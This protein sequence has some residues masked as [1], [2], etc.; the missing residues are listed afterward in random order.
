[1]KEAEGLKAGILILFNPV[2]KFKKV[3]PKAEKLTIEI[4]C[5]TFCHKSRCIMSVR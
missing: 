2:S 4:L 3:V 1:M 5:K